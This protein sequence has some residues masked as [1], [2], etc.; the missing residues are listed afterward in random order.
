M[1]GNAPNSRAGAQSFAT[2]TLTGNSVIDFAN[3]TG[4]SSITFGSISM[5]G[6]YK[7]FVYDWNGT[8]LYGTTSTTGGVGQYTHLFDS[9]MGLSQTALDNILFYS[10]SDQNSTFLGSGFYNGTEIVPVPEPSVVIAACMLL[11]WLLIA[12]R[13]TFL[14]PLRRRQS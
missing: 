1:G 7:L 5:G 10:G 11:V 14:A 3:L 13:G 12:N 8:N 4:L 2:L 6:G 9:S